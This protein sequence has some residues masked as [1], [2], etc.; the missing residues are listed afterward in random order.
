MQTNG[1]ENKGEEM[2]KLI[3]NEEEGEGGVVIDKEFVTAPR[4]V[5]LDALVDWMAELKEIY[6]SML[7]KP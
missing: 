2:I 3:W 1:E 7:A 5:Q 6:E 4:I